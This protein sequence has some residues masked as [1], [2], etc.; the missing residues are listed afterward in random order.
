MF[1][2][3]TAKQMKICHEI[4]MQSESA[5]FPSLFNQEEYLEYANLERAGILTLDESNRIVKFS[6]KLAQNYAFDAVRVDVLQ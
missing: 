1:E 3:L 5:E 6:S 4:C 2:N